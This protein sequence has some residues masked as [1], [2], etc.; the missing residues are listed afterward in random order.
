MVLKKGKK[1]IG[2]NITKLKSEGYSPAQAKAIALKTA[3]VPKAKKAK[4]KK[5]GK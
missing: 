5:K 1:N 3:D 2:P 4:G